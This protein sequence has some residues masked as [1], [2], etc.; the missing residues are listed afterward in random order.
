MPDAPTT[1]DE[2]AVR[3]VDYNP[4]NPA[5][6]HLPLFELRSI[7]LGKGVVGTTLVA[8]DSEED[9]KQADATP[10]FFVVAEPVNQ[11]KSGG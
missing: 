5:H 6:K 9:R 1:Q 10:W 4:H 3:Y 7:D 11:P 2:G 8:A